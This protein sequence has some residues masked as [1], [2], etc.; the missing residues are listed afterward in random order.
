MSNRFPA[1]PHPR[2]INSMT[3]AETGQE[4]KEMTMM[5]LRSGALAGVAG[6][7]PFGMMMT[8]MGSMKMIAGMVGSESTALSRA[9]PGRLLSPRR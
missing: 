6:G 2:T 7:I 8:A 5:N 3:A 9:Q 1:R 4:A